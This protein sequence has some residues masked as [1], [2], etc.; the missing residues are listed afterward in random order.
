[1]D[2]EAFRQRLTVGENWWWLTGTH[3]RRV[4]VHF[5]TVEGNVP[6]AIKDDHS[7]HMVRTLNP[8]GRN[9]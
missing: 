6:G 1:M 2:R 9:R 7:C 8:F 5:V 3:Y 4:G